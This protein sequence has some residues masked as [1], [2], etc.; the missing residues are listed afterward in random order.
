M[1]NQSHSKWLRSTLQIHTAHLINSPHCGELLGPIYAMLE[2]RT[3]HYSALLQLKGKL[4]MMT[5]QISA[6]AAAAAVASSSDSA[7]QESKAALLGI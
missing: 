7:A 5:K 6:K 2:A 3:K 4:D 1:V